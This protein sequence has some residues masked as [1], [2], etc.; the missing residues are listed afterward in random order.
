VISLQKKGKLIVK[1]LSH[2]LTWIIVENC[3]HPAEF[4]SEQ[5]WQ[6]L[7]QNALGA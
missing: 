4:Y 1:I 2:D 7:K 3:E 6:N 5:E